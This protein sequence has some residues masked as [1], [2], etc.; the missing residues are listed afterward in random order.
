MGNISPVLPL[1]RSRRSVTS[2]PHSTPS[3]YSLEGR[4]ELYSH[5]AVPCGQCSW[6][7]VWSGCQVSVTL[8]QTTVLPRGTEQRSWPETDC[9]PWLSTSAPETVPS[10]R[11]PGEHPLQLR[12]AAE[13]QTRTWA[14]LQRQR[15][16]PRHSHTAIQS[17]LL[18]SALGFI[19]L[20]H[21][22]VFCLKGNAQ[23]LGLV[24]ISTVGLLHFD[25]CP[26][27][28]H[29]RYTDTVGTAY[30]QY[31]NKASRTSTAFV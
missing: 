29:Q 10:A 3:H 2:S 21:L 14:V 23:T 17:V 22:A 8:G 9:E 7:Q 16:G 24:Q 25:Y 12:P 31:K 6:S 20:R 5:R 26:T 28:R 1:W 30:H 4:A 27:L 19:C 15:T 18:F 13:L 11:G